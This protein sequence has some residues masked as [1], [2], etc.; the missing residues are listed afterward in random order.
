M[1]IRAKGS[2]GF[3]FST[4]AAALRCGL[5]LRAK[6]W[7]QESDAVAALRLC[8]ARHRRRLALPLPTKA[9][10]SMPA[11]GAMLS[12]SLFELRAL[13][14]CKDSENFGAHTLDGFI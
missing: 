3:K 14:R 12:A 1:L 7:F 11:T 6:V 2:G 9:F 4:E 5:N 8:A 13:F 10:A